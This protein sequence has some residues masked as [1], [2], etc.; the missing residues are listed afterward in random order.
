VKKRRSADELLGLEDQRGSGA[1][2]E[3]EE[4]MGLL[5]DD[6]RP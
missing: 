4:A 1:V 5:R 2:R 6:Q 3:R